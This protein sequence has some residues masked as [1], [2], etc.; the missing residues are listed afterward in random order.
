MVDMKRLI[1]LYE[2]MDGVD[3]VATPDTMREG[4]Y[5]LIFIYDEN[6][7]P[8]FQEILTMLG[9]GVSIGES[10]DMKMKLAVV[11]ADNKIITAYQ[12]AE[13]GFM[14]YVDAHGNLMGEEV[15]VFDVL[16]VLRSEI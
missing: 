16:S 15:N 9:D 8:I 14:L 2:S 10:P 13:A 3:T 5:R 6:N 11:K 7:K 4:F 1:E 12:N